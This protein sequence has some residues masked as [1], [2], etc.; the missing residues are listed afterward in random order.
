[1]VLNLEEVRMVD[2]NGIGT[3]VSLLSTSRGHGE[4][5]LAALGQKMQDALKVTKLTEL[6]SIVPTVEQAIERFQQENTPIAMGE[7]PR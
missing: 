4:L 7:L 3:L 6:F 1:V 2:S 5:K